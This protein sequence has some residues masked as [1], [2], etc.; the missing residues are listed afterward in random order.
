MVAVTAT[1]RRA[2]TLRNAIPVASVSK[3][4]V[5]TVDYRE[6]PEDEFPAASEDVEKVYRATL[7][8][9][10]AENIGIYGCSAGGGLTAQVMLW[11]TEHQLPL[12]AAIGVF[13]AGIWDGPGDS[14][15][16][17]DAGADAPKAD[18][19]A[20]QGTEHPYLLGVHGFAAHLSIPGDSRSPD[21][22][23]S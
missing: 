2:S 4:E 17:A 3:I 10:G 6:G 14:Q 12:P 18:K 15:R 13:C 22:R 21:H 7:Q 19:S 9:H 20:G 5:I 8:H 11:F 16:W 23:L 1:S